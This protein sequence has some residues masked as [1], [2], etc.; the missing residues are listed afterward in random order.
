MGRTKW[1]WAGTRTW[2]VAVRMMRTI[3]RKVQEMKRGAM[4][5]EL[6]VL[7]STVIL[8]CSCIDSPAVTLCHLCLQYCLPSLGVVSKNLP[9]MNGHIYTPYS[10][11]ISNFLALQAAFTCSGGEVQQGNLVLQYFQVLQRCSISK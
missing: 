1:E 11:I 9:M 8:F 2:A 4:R 6:E 5:S 7:S 3:R 10:P